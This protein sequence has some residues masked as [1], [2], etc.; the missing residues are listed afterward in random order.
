MATF[1][2][3]ALWH[4]VDSCVSALFLP[5]HGPST[6][7]PTRP[8]GC[9]A[10]LPCQFSVGSGLGF[11]LSL[12]AVW[13]L[14]CNPAPYGACRFWC[15][16]IYL[17]IFTFG[18]CPT[19]LGRFPSFTPC[20]G[21]LISGF[22]MQFFL[23]CYSM[24]L[25]CFCTWVFH[26]GSFSRGLF[27]LRALACWQ[28]LLASMLGLLLIPCLHGHIPW[29]GPLASCWF[30]SVCT[31]PSS[32]W[33]F[34]STVISTHSLGCT[35]W[36]HSL[37]VLS[38]LG[39][40]LFVVAVGCLGV[41]V[42]PSALRGPAIFCSGWQSLFLPMPLVFSHL[43]AHLHFRPLSFSSRLF[44]VIRPLRWSPYLF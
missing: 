1:L 17:L 16:H 35:A 7:I 24:F 33:S 34:G 8:L 18:P 31:F 23:G 19:A 15:F 36:P 22:H 39:S 37:P 2:G 43:L 9:T 26:V 25:L 11:L 5:L 41:G 3:P 40:R 13:V 27:S 29:S 14:V 12:R 42:Q 30:L 10:C 20:G 38:G 44:P 6:V 28:S 4:P 21:P 32:V